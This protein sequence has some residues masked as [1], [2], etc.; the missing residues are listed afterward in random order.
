M[1]GDNRYDLVDYNSSPSATPVGRDTNPGW[2]DMHEKHVELTKIMH[3]KII[4]CGDSIVAGLQRYAYIWNKY[5]E[6]RGALNCGIRGDQ[7]QHVLWRMENITLP[8][9]VRYAVIHCG[10]NNIDR[11]SPRNI[12]NGVISSGL[13]LQEQNRKL[14]VIIT[15]LIPRDIEE[16]YR[17][18]KIKETNKQLRRYCKQFTN[19]TYMEQDS[20]WVRN[21][22]TLNA[23]LYYTDCSGV[24]H[25]VISWYL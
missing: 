22:G 2:Y 3:P 13:V 15:G 17:R 18:H 24:Y 10:T 4:L 11:D 25:R 1:S 8:E 6:P 19:F 12:A 14:K 9:T 7:T 21:D 23:K 5:F 20:D 16:S